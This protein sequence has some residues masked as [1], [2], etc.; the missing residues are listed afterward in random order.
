MKLVIQQPRGD[1]SKKSWR[2]DGTRKNGEREGERRERAR[3]V[4]DLLSPIRE[5]QL[6]FRNNFLFLEVSIPCALSFSF[7]PP[8]FYSIRDDLDFF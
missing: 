5:T 6:L 7:S 1:L 2:D 3:R 4:P 8:S